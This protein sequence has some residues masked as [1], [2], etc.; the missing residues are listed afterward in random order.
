MVEEL[1]SIAKKITWYTGKM[2]TQTRVSLATAPVFDSLIRIKV[3]TLIFNGSKPCSYWES[4]NK[5]AELLPNSMIVNIN[6]ACHDPWF[7]NPQ[8]F[9]KE[10]NKFIRKHKKIK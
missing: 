1:I 4:V 6:G 10:S 3:P 5:Y 2:S 7:S 9:R 8:L